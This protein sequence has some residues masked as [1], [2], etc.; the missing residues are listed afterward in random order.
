MSPRWFSTPRLTDWPS[1]AMWLWPWVEWIIWASLIPCGGGVEYLHRGLASRRRRRKGK[2]RIWDSKIWSRVPRHSDPRMTTL[3]RA[4]SNCKRQTL[5]LIRESAPHQQAC[6]C[7]TVIKIWSWAP[8]GCFIPRQTR[9]LTV[10]RNIRLRLSESVVRYSP[11]SKNVSRGHCRVVTSCV[12]VFSKSSHHSKPRLQSLTHVTYFPW[13]WHGTYV[14][15]LCVQN[16][17][18]HHCWYRRYT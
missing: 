4:S 1:V 14:G 17:V 18:S 7:L 3:A 10:G 6:N 13:Q 16:A 12:Y 5:P 9:R 15:R 8:E 11:A 2:S